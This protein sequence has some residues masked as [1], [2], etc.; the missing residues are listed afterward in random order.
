M[1][2]E[3]NFGLWDTVRIL[4][5]VLSKCIRRER[6]FEWPGVVTASKGQ[7]SIIIILLPNEGK[8][9]FGSLSVERPTASLASYA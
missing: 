7:L 2:C 6:I 8:R 5:T 3:V 4:K 1:P 9:V